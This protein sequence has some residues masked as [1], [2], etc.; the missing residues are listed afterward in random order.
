MWVSVEMGVVRSPFSFRGEQLW[1]LVPEVLK[2][3]KNV[4]GV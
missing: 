4:V 3:D 2:E 1:I